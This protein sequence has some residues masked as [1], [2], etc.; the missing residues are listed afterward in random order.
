MAQTFP[1][2]SNKFSYTVK[3]HS[4]LVRIP[5]RETKGNLS[6]EYPNPSQRP[7]K[8]VPQPKTNPQNRKLEEAWPRLLQIRPQ[9]R[10]SSPSDDS[11]PLKQGLG[12]RILGFAVYFELRSLQEP[13]Y[14]NNNRGP[15]LRPPGSFF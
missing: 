7:V 1:D 12:G 11:E 8:T 3:F 9:K 6:P 4:T 2:R 14:N 15:P 13:K 10:S 5:E